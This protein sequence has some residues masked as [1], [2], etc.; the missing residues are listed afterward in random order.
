MSRS[1]YLAGRR[2]RSAAE[3]A[4][5][6]FA[7]LATCR[8]LSGVRHKVVRLVLDP[9][10]AREYMA[11]DPHGWFESQS[12]QEPDIDPLSFDEMMPFLAALPDPKWMRFYT[13]AFG[14]GLRPSEQF[15][16]EWPHVDFGRRLLLVRRGFVDGRLTL[17][18][19]RGARRDVDMLP[20]VEDA[21]REHW[22]A[23]QGKGSYVFS[24][25]AG[26]LLHRDNLRNRIW[27]PTLARAG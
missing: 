17:F 9:A 25:A 7:T 8:G 11:K 16:L 1:R 18:K 10:Y 15:A 19:T 27:N 3:S 4:G 26:G 14:T 20:S 23:A 21:L 5:V 13:V 6:T 22:E 24:N 2:H 12:E